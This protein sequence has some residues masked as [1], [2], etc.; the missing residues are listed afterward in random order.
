LRWGGRPARFSDSFSPVF[1]SNVLP[2][3]AVWLAPILTLIGGFPS[4]GPALTFTILADVTPQAERATTYFHLNAAFMLAELLSNPL[5]GL[6]LDVH[7]WVALLVGLGLIT[8][9]GV[10]LLPMPETL[11]LIK[12]A[13]EQN[14]EVPGEAGDA[15]E[16]PPKESLRQKVV[17]VV[18]DNTVEMW[19]F[20]LGNRTLVLLMIPT[21]FYIVGRFVQTLLLQYA[22]KRYDMSWSK[23][24]WPPARACVAS[25]AN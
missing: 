15:D 1:F 2:L 24:G 22:T 14:G 18:R 23:V 16:Q 3:W 6:L 4:V 17:R 12:K 19:T 5:G 8:L 20:I 9:V 21:L 11:D 25:H 13:D 7:V 10:V